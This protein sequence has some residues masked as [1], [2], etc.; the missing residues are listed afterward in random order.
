RPAPYEKSTVRSLRIQLPSS[1]ELVEIQNRVVNQEVAAER[2]ASPDWIVREEDDVSLVERRVDDGRMLR[3]LAAVLD[4]TRHEQIA[5]VGV[6]Q[7]HARARRGRD[8][9]DAVAQLLVGDG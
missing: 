1:A 5:R 9:V 2:L 6:A 8:D 7:N 4:E 3:D